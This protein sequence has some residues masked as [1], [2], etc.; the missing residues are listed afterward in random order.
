[1]KE[2]IVVSD[3]LPVKLVEKVLGKEC[4]TLFIGNNSSRWKH[5]ALALRNKD[6]LLEHKGEAVFDIPLTY[7]TKPYWQYEENPGSPS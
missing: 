7:D 6:E 3:H 5:I 1:M 4:R 2:F